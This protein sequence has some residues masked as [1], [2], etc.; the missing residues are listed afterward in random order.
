MVTTK[1]GF[2]V[3]LKN[4]MN[5]ND[6]VERITAD[7]TSIF[8]AKRNA[9]TVIETADDVTITLSSSVKFKKNT[10]WRDVVVDKV[11]F[12]YA[13]YFSRIYFSIDDK[14]E[15]GFGIFHSKITDSAQLQQT[16]DTQH[17]KSKPC[18]NGMSEEE[19]KKR[20]PHLKIDGTHNKYYVPT[21][22][23]PSHK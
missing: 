13:D 9:I 7:L 18:L 8:K 20:N 14:E 5:N 11:I 23:Q 16:A 15:S 12:E 10:K 4:K 6:A 2:R 19:F 3:T 22:Y 17:G 21:D 1:Y